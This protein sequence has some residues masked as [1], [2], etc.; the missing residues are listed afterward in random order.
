MVPRLLNFLLF[1]LHTQFFQPEEYGVFTKLMSVVAVLNIVYTFGMETAYFRFATKPGADE[2]R[3]FNVAQTVVT[4][5]S[6]LFSLSFIFF[7]SSFASLLNV[8]H[9]ENYIIW[10]SLIM[11]IDNVV[12][13]PF[14]RLRLHKKPVQF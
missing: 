1:P 13:I 2:K 14:A 4:S 7:A 11:F 9:H 10:L 8:S 12:S 3:V 5:I 6:A